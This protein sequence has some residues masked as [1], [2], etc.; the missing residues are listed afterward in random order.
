MHPYTVKAVD[1]AGVEH[2]L[3]AE[4]VTHHN[5]TLTLV[6]PG[7]TTCTVDV[8]SVANVMNA[9]GQNVALYRRRDLAG[10]PRQ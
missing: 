9:A 2:I 1:A 8:V 10:R 4:S 5:N 6:T 3:A 7:G